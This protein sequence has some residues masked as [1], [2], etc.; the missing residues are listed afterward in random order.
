[1]FTRKNSISC[2]IFLKLKKLKIVLFSVL[3]LGLTTVSCGDDD[4]SSAT[5]GNLEGKWIYAKEGMAAQGQEILEDHEH[6][7]GCNKDYLEFLSNGT[8]K[9]VSYYGSDCSQ[10]V[11]ESTYEKNGNTLTVTEDGQTVTV[12]I[13]KLTGSELRISTSENLG[14]TTVKYISTFTKG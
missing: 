11:Y 10:D 2:P 14:G 13:E 4:S 1:M 8:A 7:A 5:G 6:Y 12:T 3:A 9:D